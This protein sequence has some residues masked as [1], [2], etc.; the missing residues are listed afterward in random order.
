MSMNMF[1]IVSAILL[2]WNKFVL[3]EKSC[4]GRYVS[5]NSCNS[6]KLLIVD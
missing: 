2:V 4:V 6:N 3:D 5:N 1:R